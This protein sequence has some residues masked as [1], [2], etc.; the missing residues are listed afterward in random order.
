MAFAE[1]MAGKQRP[2]IGESEWTLLVAAVAAV[3]FVKGTAL[4]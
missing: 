2:A 4:A 3:I 1:P